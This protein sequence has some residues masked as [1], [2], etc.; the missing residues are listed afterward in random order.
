MGNNIL[1]EAAK[2]LR[3]KQTDAET[4][5]WFK[6]KA[7]HLKGFKFRRQEPIGTYIVDFVSFEKKLIV[8][9][10][11]SPHREEEIRINDNQRSA[12]LKEQGFKM[13][14]FWNSD[15]TNNIDMVLEKITRE[16]M[17]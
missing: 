14:R 10:D 17:R 12:W 13:L 11:G 8:E 1:T 9:V 7:K 3:Q 6:L 16:T 4:I 5:L 2:E 15:V